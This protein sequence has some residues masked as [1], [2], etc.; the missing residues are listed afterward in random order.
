MSSSNHRSDHEVFVVVVC[1][2]VNQ[3]GP[4]PL[5]VNALILMEQVSNKFW[6]WID[7]RAIVRRIVLFVTLWMTWE[8]FQWAAEFAE[9]TTKSGVEV[10]AIV[11]AVTA[12]IAALQGYVFKIY[13][14]TRS[15]S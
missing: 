13:A 4:D 7:T 3:C 14:A 2:R 11:A 15:D 6:N 8:A 12:P 10:A 1:Y 5:C 9:T